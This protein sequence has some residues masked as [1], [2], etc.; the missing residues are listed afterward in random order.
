MNWCGGEHADNLLQPLQKQWSDVEVR[1][2]ETPTN[3]RKAHGDI[4]LCQNCRVMAAVRGALSSAPGFGRFP[5]VF[6]TCVQLSPS[7]GSEIGS[8]PK[9]LMELYI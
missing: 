3:A 6:H 5:L 9:L 4:F 2:S 1:W 7:C 8:F